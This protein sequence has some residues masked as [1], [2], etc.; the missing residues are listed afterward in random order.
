MKYTILIL[1]LLIIG[2]G[3]KE[4]MR[5]VCP[6]GSR[7]KIADFVKSSIKDANNMSDEEMEDVV[8]Q[9]H[10]T[11]INIYCPLKVVQTSYDNEVIYT[12]LDS[13]EFVQYYRY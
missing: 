10:S 3:R 4:S 12:K 8:R 6:C 9:L 11:A 5:N 7:E 13:C 1:C 2:C